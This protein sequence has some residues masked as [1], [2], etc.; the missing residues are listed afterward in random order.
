MTNETRTPSTLTHNPPFPLA[1]AAAMLSRESLRRFFEETYIPD[2][3]FRVCS[4]LGLRHEI[5]SQTVVQSF[6]HFFRDNL[7]EVENLL[8]TIVDDG[9]DPN[10]FLE[11][12]ARELAEH[13]DETEDV[14]RLR[15]RLRRQHLEDRQRGEMRCDACGDEL[16]V[17]PPHGDQAG[18]A[19]PGVATPTFQT[20]GETSP[21]GGPSQPL[22]TEDG[23]HAPDN[24]ESRR[25]E[26]LEAMM[27]KT[28]RRMMPIEPYVEYEAREETYRR[29]EWA[30]VHLPRGGFVVFHDDRPLCYVVGMTVSA[31]IF[32]R[33]R[34]GRPI[35]PHLVPAARAWVGQ[36]MVPRMAAMHW[37]IGALEMNERGVMQLSVDFRCGHPTVLIDVLAYL[38]RRV[39]TDLPVRAIERLHARHGGG[40]S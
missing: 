15:E 31:P 26:Q 7:H 2:R 34:G 5:S 20:H 24:L 32:F 29:P 33:W 9:G 35:P 10:H 22:S 27:L 3:V 17:S 1:T 23:A 37:E 39:E 13:I 28:L 19:V 38:D 40:A 36:N 6:A 11:F 18:E 21:A 4:P 12:M 30:Y 8:R 25:L 14:E 16:D